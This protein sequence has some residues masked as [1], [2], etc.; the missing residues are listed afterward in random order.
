MNW[1]DY[2]LIALMLFS[3]M[4]GVM[5]GLLREAIALVAWVVAVWSAFHFSGELE[6]YL[7]GLLTNDALRPWVA[8]LLIFLVV[9]LIGTMLGTIVSYFVRLSMF[10]GM[11]RFWGALFGLVRGL[12]VIGAFV[13]LC[14]GLRLNTEPWWHHSA[15]APHAER[16]ANVLRALTGERKI[17]A[18]HSSSVSD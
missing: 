4:A 6:P 9:V 17:P 2:L 18:E 15:L 16:V 11:D 1:F 7:G 13:I 8:R 14:H 3:V 5:R 12:V 10:S